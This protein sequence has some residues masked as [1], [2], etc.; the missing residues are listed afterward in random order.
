MVSSQ[1]NTEQPGGCLMVLGWTKK[2]T[3]WYQRQ[4][5]FSLKKV[6]FWG[7]PVIQAVEAKILG[8]VYKKFMWLKNILSLKKNLSFLS[9]TRWDNW[10]P[11]LIPFQFNSCVHLHWK[12]LRKY[13]TGVES[14]IFCNWFLCCIKYNSFLKNIG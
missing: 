7:H 9:T 5:K 3:F 12:T 11:F 6:Y 2:S 10:F 4:K 13:N 1:K 14:R 8:P